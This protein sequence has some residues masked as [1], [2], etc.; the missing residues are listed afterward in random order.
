MYKNTMNQNPEAD[1][2]SFFKETRPLINNDYQPGSIKSDEKSIKDSKYTRVAKFLILIGSNQA[3]GIL[4]ELEPQQV[5]EISKE[6]AQ[7]K[8]IKPHEREEILAEFNTLFSNREFKAYGSTQGGVETAR[9]ILYAAKGAVK[10]EEILNKAI[11]QSKENLFGF[12]EEFSTEQL[13]MLLKNESAQ[14]SALI[15]SRLQPKLTAGVLCRLPP[16]N[17]SDVVL[18]IA[19]QQE[20]SP[21]ILE[22]V[23]AALKEKVRNIAGGA[24]DIEIDGMKTLAAI[25]KQSGYSFG[26]RLLNEIEEDD[27]EMGHEL[28]EKLY[29]LDDVI[30]AVDRPIQDKLKTMTE[31]E[32]AVLLK[33]RGNDFNEKI[34]SCVSA[35]RRKIIREEF[36]LIGSVPK[37]E[38][39]AAAKDFLSWFRFG[40]EKGDIILYSD[41]D[42]FV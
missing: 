1:G 28:K 30:N 10:G 5:Q 41:E 11:P 38:C 22:Q 4:A 35:G 14:T 37:R 2:Q 31:Y 6:I 3:A 21:E 13:V 33:G 8:I 16:E 20:V 12:L 19:H 15:L 17:I 26:D 32:I 7:I 40:R 36:E 18:R 9:R 23:S 29:T 25:L 34:L 42:V 24:K 39:D 27:P